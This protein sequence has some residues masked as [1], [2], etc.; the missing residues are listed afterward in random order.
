MSLSTSKEA[1]ADYFASLI[2]ESRASNEKTAVA[3]YM[4]IFHLL[5]SS[6]FPRAYYYIISNSPACFTIPTDRSQM[7]VFW[8]LFSC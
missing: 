7:N 5:R 8:N 1:L 3:I 6:M 2:L 4:H